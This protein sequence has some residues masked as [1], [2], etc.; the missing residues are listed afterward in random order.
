M[1]AVHASSLR[2]A[3]MRSTHARYELG[4][5]AQ[6]KPLAPLGSHISTPRRSAWHVASWVPEHAVA[7]KSETESSDR[8]SIA[9]L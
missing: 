1:N 3:G 4:S 6:V 8:R 2:R 5:P 7:T 9:R